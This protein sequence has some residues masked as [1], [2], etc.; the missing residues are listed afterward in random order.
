MGEKDLLRREVISG[1][2]EVQEPAVAVVAV[3][4]HQSNG[5]LVLDPPIFGGLA[6]QVLPINGTRKETVMSCRDGCSL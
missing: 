5:Y 2:L 3:G 1:E 4:E 6:I